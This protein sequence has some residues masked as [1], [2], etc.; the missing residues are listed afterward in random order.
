MDYWKKF[1]NRANNFDH[2][3]EGQENIPVDDDE[4]SNNQRPV[5]S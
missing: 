3:Q 5:P 2:Y 4:E 1:I